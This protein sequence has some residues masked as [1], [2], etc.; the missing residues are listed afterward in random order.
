MSM[1][2]NPIQ[3]AKSLLEQNY[4]EDQIISSLLESHCEET[5]AYE[6]LEQAKSAINSFNALRNN[7]HKANS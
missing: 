3:I 7:L 6:A 2:F 5:V 1:L 4:S